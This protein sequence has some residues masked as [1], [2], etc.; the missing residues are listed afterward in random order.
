MDIQ[1]VLALGKALNELFFVSVG[2]IV[3]TAILANVADKAIA[4]WNL[5]QGT[6]R[7][8]KN[9]TRRGTLR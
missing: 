4:A 1:T 5:E 8:H 6:A 2:G 3:G 7:N 9:L